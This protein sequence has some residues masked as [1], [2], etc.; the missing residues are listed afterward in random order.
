VLYR[1]NRARQVAIAEDMKLSQ[2]DLI[3]TPS[4]NQ[5]DVLQSGRTGVALCTICKYS[6]DMTKYIP[7]YM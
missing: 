6:F 3:A 1:W 5:T 2:F 4:A 7:S